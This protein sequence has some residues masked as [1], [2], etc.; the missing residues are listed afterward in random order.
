MKT[1]YMLDT[2]TC[3]YVIQGTSSKLKAK[4][5]A[6]KAQICISSITL[7][8]LLFGARKRDSPRLTTAIELLQELVDVHPWTAETAQEY[9][10]IRNALEKSGTPIGNMDML[11]AAAARAANACLVTNNRAHFSR[12]AGLKLENWLE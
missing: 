6:H 2:D 3:S 11:I 8:E 5:K 9:A 10:V 1:V 4:I 7:A 12:I